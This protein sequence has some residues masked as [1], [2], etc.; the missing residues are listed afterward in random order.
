MNFDLQLKGQRAL[1]TGRDPRSGAPLTDTSTP[2]RA[3]SEAVRRGVREVLASGDLRRKPT[4]VVAGRSDALLPVNNAARAYTAFNQAVEG[5]AS[6]LR[7]VEDTHGQ[8]F[9]GFLGFSVFFLSSMSTRR[10]SWIG[11]VTMAGDQCFVRCLIS[12][13]TSGR[14]SFSQ[15]GSIPSK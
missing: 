7:Y 1:V 11:S 9:D 4:L 8:H 10:A 15:S 5:G 12:F 14:A 3:Q 13:S 2:T 6:G